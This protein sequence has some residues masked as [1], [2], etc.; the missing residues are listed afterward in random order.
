MLAV[1]FRRGWLDL[2]ITTYVVI[3]RGHSTA[4]INT[5]IRSPANLIFGSTKTNSFP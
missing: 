5:Y 2:A 1:A 3:R 4:C